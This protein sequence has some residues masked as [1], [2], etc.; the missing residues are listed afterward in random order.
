[1]RILPSVVIPAHIR[2]LV[3]AAAFTALM[4]TSVTAE[5]QLRDSAWTIRGGSYSGITVP[6]D[7]RAATHRSK[8][9]R[10]S[11]V[12]GVPRVIGW[13]PSRLPVAVAFRRGSGVTHADSAGFWEILKRLE[14]DLGLKVFVP[15]RLDA[16]ADPEDVIVVD[17]QRIQSDGLTFITWSTHGSL[18]DAR[19]FL[20]SRAT[21]HDERVV[22]HEMMHALGFGHTSAWHS[23]MNPIRSYAGR[24]SVEDVAYVQ[25]AMASR[26]SSERDD[27]W[28]RLALAV[29]REHPL[30]SS[31]DE[32]EF[33]NRP[34]GF[35]RF[36]EACMSFR[37]SVDGATCAVE[38]STAPLP[39]R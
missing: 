14:Q 36:P 26:A 3:R 21:L 39:E 37:C 8:F 6:V 7:F 1:M 16:D 33:L 27:M 9:W 2:A 28:D 19:V 23:V 15:A 31:S 22:T 34:L 10:L 4:M 20:R 25:L 35:L 32:C 29:E 38:R 5:A 17:V 12:R 18:Y 24:L 11:T 30:P 13:N